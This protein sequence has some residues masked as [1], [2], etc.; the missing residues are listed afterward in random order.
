MADTITTGFVWQPT[1][2]NWINCLQVSLDWYDI[3]MTNANTL[4]GI[5]R[6]VD[7]CFA[8]SAASVCDLILRNPSTN[9]GVTPGLISLIQNQNINAAK[10]ETRGVDFETSYRFDPDFFAGQEVKRVAL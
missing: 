3:N 9:S 1:F 8:T 2:A 10:A 7:D 5:Q 6:N 4:Y